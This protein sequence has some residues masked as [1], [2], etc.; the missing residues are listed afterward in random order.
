[1]MRALLALPLLLTL[2]GCGSN[3]QTRATTEKATAPGA[4]SMMPY[5][6]SLL[7]LF[8][9]QVGSWSL[10]S[11]ENVPK[12]PSV[13]LQPSDLAGA[14]YNEPDNPDTLRVILFNFAT[15]DEANKA[16]LEI[17]KIEDQLTTQDKKMTHTVT[18]E[19]N[20]LVVDLDT[21]E[22][23]KF[24]RIYFTNGSVIVDI[25]MMH[26]PKRATEFEENFKRQIQ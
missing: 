22:L 24:R 2:M 16:L 9:K 20:R 12:N 25:D 15:V 1:M 17:R 14:S 13:N 11:A 19:A 8:P 23:M 26:P 6:G 18:L 21:H 10:T 3:T 7:T 4:S 5:R